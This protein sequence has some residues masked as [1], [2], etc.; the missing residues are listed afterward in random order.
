MGGD[1]LRDALA[2][3]Q[4][5]GDQVEGISAVDLGAGRAAGRTAVVAADEEL[6]GREGRGVE[7]LEDAADLSGPRVDVVLGAMAVE[8]DRV[9]AAAEAGELLDDFRQGAVLGQL[10][11]VRK[12]GRGGAG[13]DGF[14]P[15]GWLGREWGPW[16]GGCLAV[17]CR[18]GV[19]CRSAAAVVAE[20]RAQDHGG[21]GNGDGRDGDGRHESC[22]DHA[23]RD[24][25]RYRAGTHRDLGKRA[26]HGCRFGRSVG[27]RGRRGRA[28][29][30]LRKKH[31]WVSLSTRLGV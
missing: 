22:E 8:A 24:D 7:V 29:G 1:V 5:G 30:V 4:A 23:A 2:A 26:L 25:G 14:S 15:S 13:E 31:G 20:Q 19:Q 28:V 17:S 16:G 11:E 18:P 27:V 10:R 12:R 9:G 3:A 6:A 21:D